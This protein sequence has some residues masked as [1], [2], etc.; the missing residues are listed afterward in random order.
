MDLLRKNI[1]ELNDLEKS[2]DKGNAFII[3]QL[4]KVMR[5]CDAFFDG[6]ERWDSRLSTEYI[7]V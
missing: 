1:R 6:K 7:I 2:K 4:E 3:D 5:V